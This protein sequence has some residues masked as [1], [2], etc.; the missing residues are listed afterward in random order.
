MERLADVIERKRVIIVQF[1]GGP[2]YGFVQIDAMTAPEPAAST[3]GCK[4]RFSP[5]LN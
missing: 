2:H 3:S 5:L 1:S 4:A